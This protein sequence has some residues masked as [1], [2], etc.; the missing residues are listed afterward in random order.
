MKI[1]IEKINPKPNEVIVWTF[2][3]Q[4]IPVSYFPNMINK[5]QSYFPNNKVIGI[6]DN[7]VLKSCGKDVLEKIM[8]TVATVLKEMEH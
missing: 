3:L 7:S 1:E 8:S 2:P 6:P 5:I 4:Q